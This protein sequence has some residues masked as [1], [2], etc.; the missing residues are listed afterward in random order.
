MSSKKVYN[1]RVKLP[2]PNFNSGKTKQNKRS[3][4]SL[5]V[6]VQPA[7]IHENYK[8]RVFVNNYF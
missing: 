2:V 4:L 8:T 3:L 7:L 1:F 5:L 6:L